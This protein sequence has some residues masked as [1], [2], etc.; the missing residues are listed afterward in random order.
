[1]Y[2]RTV[3]RPRVKIRLSKLEK[4]ILEKC[5]DRELSQEETFYGFYGSHEDEDINE[6]ESKISVLKQKKGY[7]KRSVE[8]YRKLRKLKAKQK[9]HRSS[10][11]L[12][13]NQLYLQKLVK[14]KEEGSG[15]W[16]DID[17]E[18]ERYVSMTDED[19][20]KSKQIIKEDPDNIPAKFWLSNLFDYR[21]A[22]LGS[23]IILTKEWNKLANEHR[24]G[25]FL[26]VGSEIG[27]LVWPNIISAKPVEGE[28]NV[29]EKSKADS[30]S[31]NRFGQLL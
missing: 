26:F 6:L 1:M 18:V 21:E 17:E 27:M 8:E 2:P 23:H 25:R 11:K 7:Y 10:V 13:F 5:K 12:A 4:W 28:L 24:P 29:C 22:A 3:K 30:P 20:E 31:V 14:S 9:R 19:I 15:E 16:I